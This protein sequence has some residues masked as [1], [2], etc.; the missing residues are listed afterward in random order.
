MVCGFTVSHYIRKPLQ[1]LFDLLLYKTWNSPLQLLYS[2]LH[3]IFWENKDVLSH[4][5]TVIVFWTHGILVCFFIL[6]CKSDYIYRMGIE[7]KTWGLLWVTNKVCGTL[8]SNE[9]QFS[10]VQSLSRVRL[11]ATPWIA[12]CQASLSITISQSSLRLKSIE[13]VSAT[14]TMY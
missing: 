9:V 1:F 3:T 2:S 7:M 12:A 8:Y 13:S 14:I 6:K 10:S 4:S 11:F 5:S